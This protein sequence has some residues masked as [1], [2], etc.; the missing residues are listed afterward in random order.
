MNAQ[1]VLAIGAPTSPREKAVATS[2]VALTGALLCP[3]ATV[4]AR[5]SEM[6]AAPPSA[7]MFGYIGGPHQGKLILDTFLTSRQLVGGL[8]W[9]FAAAVLVLPNRMIRWRRNERLRKAFINTLR[10]AKSEQ[11]LASF[12]A[13]VAH[14]HRAAQTAAAP[15]AAVYLQALARGAA[16]RRCL[17]CLAQKRACAIQCGTPNKK[18]VNKKARLRFPKKYE[19]RG[20]A[21]AAT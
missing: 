15:K 14:R 13:T 20:W 18:Q 12:C 11:N 1:R 9:T 3:H 19:A 5:Q 4:V 7:V 17:Q 21:S 8:A 16:V 10:S 6:G 2:V